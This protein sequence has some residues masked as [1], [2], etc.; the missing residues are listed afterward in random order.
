MSDFI[1]AIL[2]RLE[3][4]FDPQSLSKLLVAWLM[5]LI[6]AMAVMAAFYLLCLMARVVLRVTLR[7]KWIQQLFPLF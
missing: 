7:Q 5:N 2:G 4:I 6:I 1:A 3:K